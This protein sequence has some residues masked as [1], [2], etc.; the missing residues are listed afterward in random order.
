MKKIFLFLLMLPLLLCSCSND[1]ETT[2]TS[3]DDRLNLNISWNGKQYTVPCSLDKNGNLRYW[4]E[5]F[6]E[7]YDKEIAKY[8]GKS[9]VTYVTGN[10]SFTYYSS[11]DAMM[12]DL[13]LRFIDQYTYVDGTDKAATRTVASSAVAGR[14]TMWKYTDYTGTVLSHVTWY[15]SSYWNPRLSTLKY[16]DVAQSVRVISNIPLDDEVYVNFSDVE[17]KYNEGYYSSNPPTG[18]NKYSTNRLRVVFL[19]YQ[20]TNYGGNMLCIIPENSNYKQY[21]LSNWGWHKKISSDVIRIAVENLY[22]EEH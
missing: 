12:K 19:A 14:V 9:L 22:T 5:E 3:A 8:D 7:V 1:D 6:N 20:N 2:A 4:N 18:S 21:D 11:L 13:G 16:N 17:F 10:N 15:T